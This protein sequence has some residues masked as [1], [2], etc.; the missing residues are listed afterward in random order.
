MLTRRET[1]RWSFSSK[2]NECEEKRNILFSVISLSLPAS[3]C[4]Y[5]DRRSVVIWSRVRPTA[6]ARN[7]RVTEPWTA[8]VMRIFNGSYLFFPIKIPVIIQRRRLPNAH[9]SRRAHTHKTKQRCW[10]SI[11]LAAICTTGIN[12]TGRN[13][14]DSSTRSSS[15]FEI[16]INGSAQH[17]TLFIMFNLVDDEWI[18]MHMPAD[19]LC[20]MSVCIF[21]DGWIDSSSRRTLACVCVD[22]W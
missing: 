12:R 11:I 18:S 16:L 5:F 22:I 4:L 7:R 8:F 2:S 1:E 15:L 9:S 19:T 17:S 20:P 21:V 10:W 6:R 3:F 14:D 13:G